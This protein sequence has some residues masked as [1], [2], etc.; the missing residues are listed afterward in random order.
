MRFEDLLRG[1]EVLLKKPVQLC[2]QLSHLHCQVSLRKGLAAYYSWKD[3]RV[4]KAAQRLVKKGL[5][6]GGAS[7]EEY[8]SQFHIRRRREH[9]ER[10]ALLT[11]CATFLTSLRTDS[12]F[13]L[14]TGDDI[15]IAFER[16]SA[17]LPVVHLANF[18]VNPFSTTLPLFLHVLL[19]TFKPTET[20][21]VV[22]SMAD[23]ETVDVKVLSSVQSATRLFFP[24]EGEEERQG[25]PLTPS[26]KSNPLKTVGE[27]FK[28]M[29][30]HSPLSSFLG[31]GSTSQSSVHSSE[32]SPRPVPLRRRSS[33]DEESA[34]LPLL[35]VVLSGMTSGLALSSEWGRSAD[36]G[37][38]RPGQTLFS[39]QIDEHFRP[40]QLTLDNH[41][42][43]AYRVYSLLSSLRLTL[44]PSPLAALADRPVPHS[45]APRRVRAEAP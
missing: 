44:S 40:N 42:T 20:E 43:A 5:M 6:R 19:K 10:A 39:V 22:V 14:H 23:E 45:S 29:A 37:T 16:I 4:E 24:D 9:H 38:I 18:P 8:C 28:T 7:V 33:G 12:T 11:I 34:S 21:S 3:N 25:R 2:I 17:T 15:A 31:G 13:R 1:A 32:S 26:M 35:H 41:V 27:K 30:A 36:S